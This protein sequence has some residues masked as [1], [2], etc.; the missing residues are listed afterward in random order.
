MPILTKIQPV[1]LID[2]KNVLLSAIR[3]ATSISGPCPPFGNELKTSAQ[4]Q[5]EYMLGE[6]NDTQFLTAD[7]EVKAEVR[8]GLSE[9]S[10]S[11]EREL[12]S[13]FLEFD[14]I[15]ET[16]ENKIMQSLSD[17]DWMCSV[18]PKMDLMK[19]F[20]VN[21]AELSGNILRVV[22]DKKLE[23]LMWGFKVKLMEVTA[24][25]LEAVGYG[26]III[27]AP[28]RVQLL[29]AWLPFMRKMKPLLDSLGNE[30]DSF[31]YKMDEDLCQSIEGAIVSLILALPSNDQADILADWMKGEQARY[32]DLTEAFEV[33]CYRTKSAKRRLLEC[34]ERDGKDNATLALDLSQ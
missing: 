21:W 26:T 30:D 18:L 8:M 15:S 28:C 19:D 16:T 6:D 5:V 22:Q 1:N 13:L 33:W 29:K 4:E 7:E 23:S 9:M 14:L 24:K 20:V 11:F 27:P 17:L 32:P 2:T 34:M 3:F 31:P 10:L 25:V 12:S